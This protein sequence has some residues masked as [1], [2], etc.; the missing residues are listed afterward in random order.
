MKRWLPFAAGLWLVPVCAALAEDATYQKEKTFQFKLDALLRGEWTRDIY[1]LTPTTAPNEDRQ[2]FQA[3]PAL[4]AHFGP[5]R[6][7]VGAEFNYSSDKNYETATGG[8]PTIIR[9]NYKSR[10]ARVDLAFAEFENSWLR[11]QG[12]RFE[13]PVGLTE[14]IWDKDLRPQGAAVTLGVKDKGAVKRAGITGLWAQGSHVFDDGD[15]TMSLVSANVV[16]RTGETGSLELVGSYIDFSDFQDMQPFIRRQ[17]TRV[18]GQLVFDYDVVDLVARYRR[19]GS[20]PV[21][22]VAEYGWNTAVDAS[23][24]GLWLAGVLGSLQSGIGARLDYTYA[25]ID[26]DAT[27]AAYGADDF[28]WVTGWKGHRGELG[29]RLYHQ[30]SL[31]AVGHFVQFKDSPRPDE[32]EHWWKRYRAELRFKY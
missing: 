22:L 25:K 19:G 2:R 26:K 32:R 29:F 31:H 7:G 6:L 10:D 28:F 15:A 13:M 9:D 30:L 27:L 20:V 5:V 12:G 18:A 23:N 17:N 21:Q 16:F 11:A 14:M 4:E 1:P 3:R 24:Q 8:V